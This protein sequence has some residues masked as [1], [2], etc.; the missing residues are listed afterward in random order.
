MNHELYQAFKMTNW[1]SCFDTVDVLRNP[2]FSIVDC[3]PGRTWPQN[4]VDDANIGLYNGGTRPNNSINDQVGS[5]CCTTLKCPRT[6][7]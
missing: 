1:I 3:G 4:N 2:L 7:C 5:C 6:P